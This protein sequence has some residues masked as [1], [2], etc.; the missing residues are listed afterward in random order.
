MATF[1]L[2]EDGTYRVEGEI[3]Q[4]DVN[5]INAFPI[6]TCLV[7]QNTKG[8]SSEI[9]GQITT[10]N[11]YFSVL[12][13]LDYYNK[14][15]FNN[16]NYIERTWSAPQG[17]SKILEYFEKIESEINP[18][19]TDTQKCMYVYNALAVDMEYVKLLEQDILTS[20]VTERG[21]N[22]VLYNQ[23]TCAGMA[24]TF[25]E[26]MDRLDIPCYYQNQR[27][28]HAFNVVELE[29]KLRGVDVTWDC[30]KN[31]EEKCSFKNF[32]RDS[33]FY[34]RYG[35]QIAGDKEETVFDLTT[36]TDE[37]IQ[38]NYSVIESAIEQREK[39][40]PH[41]RNFDRDRK[42]KFLPVDKF[43]ENLQAENSAIIKLL[44]LKMLEFSPEE[45]PELL[46]AINSRWGFISDYIGTN[47]EL[48]KSPRDPRNV[49]SEIKQKSN[50]PG[51]IMIKDNQI[52]LR[53]QDDNNTE[54][55]QLTEE[56]RE[57]VI[58]SLVADLKEYYLQY[59]KTE[60]AQID[61]SIESYTMI[62]NMPQEL[63]HKTATLKAHLYTQLLLFSNANTFFE[64][65]GIPKEEVELVCG[66]AQSCLECAKEVVVD[67]QSNHEY[68]LD[69]LYAIIQNDVINTLVSSSEYTKQ[70]L[71]KL[72]ENIRANWKDAEFSDDEFKTLLD[73]VLSRTTT[74][75]EISRSTVDCG[76][77]IEEV[78]DVIAEIRKMQT[79]DL[80]EVQQK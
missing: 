74:S 14:E 8:Q 18:E 6:R 19:W 35:H 61:N 69:F 33:Q 68:D 10:D 73:E 59:F 44:V 54:E 3:T 47:E 31:D 30:T 75:E 37:E 11:V 52:I 39:I 13:G 34:R 25:K 60:A 55:M 9:I 5:R 7:L 76:I 32:G 78:N 49:L 38:A 36:F 53:I 63:A 64:Q 50:L 57:N 45:A 67:S 41:F 17:L 23:L 72:M 21:L 2:I 26:M 66:K 27:S 16:S 71:T 77:G 80:Q 42:K 24:Q 12:G 79:R 62:E 48:N 46:D 65:L 20:G 70:N 40:V 51:L 1:E 28:K 22:G 43:L 29:G 4:E 56:Q 58:Q 15:K